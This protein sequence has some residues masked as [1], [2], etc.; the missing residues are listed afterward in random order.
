MSQ[1]ASRVIG[2]FGASTNDGFYELGLRTAEIIQQAIE[3]AKIVEERDAV[4]SMK[5]G[6]LDT[7]APE[8]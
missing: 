1:P 4:A 3:E 5:N 2:M 8:I 6:W 7:D